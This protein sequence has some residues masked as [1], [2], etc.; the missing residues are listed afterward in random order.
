M[1]MFYFLSAVFQSFWA[2]EDYSEAIK[3]LRPGLKSV[4][5]GI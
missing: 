4:T 2:D 3:L 5:P 1:M